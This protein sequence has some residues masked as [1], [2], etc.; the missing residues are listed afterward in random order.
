MGY[1]VGIAFTG[2]EAK[3]RIK[4]Q[5]ETHI[6]TDGN[7]GATPFHP[8]LGWLGG[9]GSVCLMISNCL[10]QHN[11]FFH[12]SYQIKARVKVEKNLSDLGT[13]FVSPVT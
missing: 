10:C 1:G 7:Q 2:T 9:G 5:S 11:T 4:L 8:R 3:N 13:F 12:S 6:H